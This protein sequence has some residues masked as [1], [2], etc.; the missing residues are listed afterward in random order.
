[1]TVKHRPTPA[2]AD[3]P[4]GSDHRRPRIGRSVHPDT[5][6]ALVLAYVALRLRTTPR[7]REAGV[8]QGYREPPHE[9]DDGPGRRALLRSHAARP[10]RWR[11]PRQGRSLDRMI[12]WLAALAAVLLAA[13][14]TMRIV[15]SSA[16]GAA[17][18][19]RIEVLSVTPRP[20]RAAQPFALVAR[21]E[22]APAPGSIR[23]NVWIGGKRFRDIRLVW[24]D[25]TARCYLR[26]PAEVVHGNGDDARSHARR[27]C[28]SATHTR[29]LTSL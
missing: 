23:C 3:P 25:P 28:A 17:G 5:R 4:A 12:S 21:V 14:A 6:L 13:A 24:D 19:V 2:S 22:F 7:T 29:D 11:A 26:L 20:P 8:A 10:R 1:M 18:D 15:A 27:E 16:H 9:H